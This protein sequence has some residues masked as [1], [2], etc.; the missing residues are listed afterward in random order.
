MQLRNL[1]FLLG[2]CTSCGIIE[3][4]LN[5]YRHLSEQ[6]FKSIKAFDQAVTNQEIDNSNGLIVYEITS[7][8]VKQIT[9]QH[10]YTWVS[11]WAP[12]CGNEA[13]KNIKAYAEVMNQY[14]MQN[15]SV[16]L[17]SNGYFMEEIN[18]AIKYSGFTKPVYVMK[19]AYFGEQMGK[20]FR[21]FANDM[22]SNNLIMK[23][24]YFS[25]YF[26][27]DTLLIYSGWELNKSTLD[28]LIK[29]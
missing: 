6:D 28:S 4:N 2:L 12:Y 11:I 9:Q 20:S 16:L 15:I 18:E 8:D 29:L 24:K 17:I 27:K 23:N 13:C 1:F 21:K 5:N 7:D 19:S 14:K 3:I 10:R 22:D 25:D 26:F